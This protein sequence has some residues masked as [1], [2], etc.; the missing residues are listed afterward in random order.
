MSKSIDE[1]RAMRGLPP[2]GEPISDEERAKVE[3]MIALCRLLDALTDAER[4]EL[5][6]CYCPGCG[7]GPY[8][9][10]E[11]RCRCWDVPEV[12]ER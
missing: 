1:I 3:G 12:D 8:A 4:A 10:D 9:A 2:G 11:T 5:F 6:A 7:Y